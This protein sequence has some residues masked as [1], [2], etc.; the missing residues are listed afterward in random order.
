MCQMVARSRDTSLDARR[1][2]SLA[3]YL[4]VLFAACLTGVV[5]LPRNVRLN[6]VSAL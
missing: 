2:F 4:A 5:S 1:S 6:A 3:V